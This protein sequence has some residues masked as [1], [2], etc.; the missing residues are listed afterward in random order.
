MRIRVEELHSEFFV[1]GFSFH[2]E[3]W[4]RKKSRWRPT[5]YIW[6]WEITII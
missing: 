5:F 4:G 3:N 1:F 2:D 6:R